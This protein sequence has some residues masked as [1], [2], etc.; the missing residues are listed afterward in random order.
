MKTLCFF[1]EKGGVG[2]TTHSILFSSFLSYVK[3]LRVLVYD[4]E[5]EPRIDRMRRSELSLLE[6][7]S[8]ALS[9]YLDRVGAPV[10]YYDILSPA[11]G[12]SLAGSSGFDV[13]Q[14]EFWKMYDKDLY[15]YVIFDFP[16][17]RHSSSF[18]GKCFASGLIDACFIP[19]DT[20]SMT[21]RCAFF[22]AD[23]ARKND[24]AVRLFWNNVSSSEISNEGF[25]DLGEVIFNNHSFEFLKTRVKSFARARRDSDSRLFVRST[26]CFPIRYVDLNC[27]SLIS[28]YEEILGTL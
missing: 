19:V 28:L 6:D 17:G 12:S 23:M 27:P 11:S 5:P 15:D 9:R 2:K 13:F 14:D 8:S 21:R 10:S 20:D 4:M 3:G 24:V 7:P 25:L 26:V 16:A 18:L 1:N 22:T